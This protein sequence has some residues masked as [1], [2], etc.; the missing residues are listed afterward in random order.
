MRSRNTW[1]LIIQVT[2]R[3]LFIP[4]LTL[5]MSHPALDLGLMKGLADF[6]IDN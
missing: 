5:Q 3:D 6:P 4:T 1:R 2:E